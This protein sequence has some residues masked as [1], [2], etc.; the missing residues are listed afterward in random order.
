MSE[1]LNPE[2]V[3]NKEGKP[4]WLTKEKDK[5]WLKEPVLWRCNR[6]GAFIQATSGKPSK[7]YTEQGGCNLASTFTKVADTID[8]SLWKL[9]TWTDL[10]K[11]DML[12]VFNTMLALIKKLLVFP[13]EI[14]YKIYILWIISTWK[15]EHWDSVGFPTFIGIPNSGKTRALLVIAELAYRALKT[16]GVSQAVIPRLCHYHNVTLLIDE[17]HD[18]LNPRK[19]MGSELLNFVKDSYI[20]GSTYITCDNDDQS[21]VVVARNFGFK[22]IAGEKSFNPALLSRSLVFW[23]DKDEPEIPK[24]SYAEKDLQSLRS[25]LLAYRFKTGCPPDLGRDFCLKG[26]TREIFES[27]ISTGKHIGVGVEDII[28][29]AK[30]RDRESAEDLK[31]TVEYDIL[32]AIKNCQ[33]NPHT[34]DDP[35]RILID[36]ILNGI[37][38]FPPEETELRKNRQ[39]IGYILKNMSLKIKRTTDGRAIYVYETH[40]ERRLEKLNKRYGI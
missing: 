12:I 24:L 14:L 4:L 33:E 23:M 32:A 35:R 10:S 27:I 30:N 13:E 21:K 22:A 2:P 25:Q 36:R 6:C 34:G 16:S 31:D 18:R 9:P 37:G 15:L 19:N 28:E 7:C 17:A 11:L 5:F 26:R 38:W 20:R 3:L 29:Y 40:N 8:T 1:S 39:K